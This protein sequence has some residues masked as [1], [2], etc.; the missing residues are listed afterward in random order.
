VVDALNRTIGPRSPPVAR[1][2]PCAATAR[3]PDA[4][5]FSGRTQALLDCQKKKMFALATSKIA[6]SRL[7]SSHEGP[8]VV[9]WARR[10]P[11]LP[12]L[13]GPCGQPCTLVPTSWHIHRPL[14]NKRMT[15]IYLCFEGEGHIERDGQNH[16]CETL[17]GPATFAQAPW[18]EGI[19][20]SGSSRNP[21]QHVPRAGLR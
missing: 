13:A 8:V 17:T 4:G 20:R 9:V 16:S 2:P 18:A 7:P 15:E 21:S 19:E 10:R 6:H 14:S 1:P 3:R 11:L 12:I 5:L